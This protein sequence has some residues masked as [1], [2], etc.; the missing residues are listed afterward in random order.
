MKQIMLLAGMLAAF[1]V[2]PALAADQPIELQVSSSPAAQFDA[3]RNALGTEDYAEITA[4]DRR[5]VLDLLD[6]MEA[7]IGDGGVDALREDRKVQVFNWQEQINTILAGAHAD[8]RVVCRRERAVGTRFATTNCAT[9]AERRKA[10][11]EAHGRLRDMAT[12]QRAPGS[13]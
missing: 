13:N 7:E 9:V 2:A 3:V 12:N 11:E 4:D 6:R 8:S 1:V 10:R 5:T